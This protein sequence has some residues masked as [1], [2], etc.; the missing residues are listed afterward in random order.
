MSIYSI[1]TR[2]TQKTAWELDDVA[3]HA[4]SHPAKSDTVSQGT[5]PGRYTLT[6]SLK[7]LVSQDTNPQS[8]SNILHKAPSF[9]T[10]FVVSKEAQLHTWFL[11]TIVI[12]AWFVTLVQVLLEHASVLILCCSCLWLASTCCSQSCYIMWYMTITH[13]WPF[14]HALQMYHD[15]WDHYNRVKPVQA[16]LGWPQWQAH[17]GQDSCY[18]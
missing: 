16:R 15:T 2:Q 13:Q 1:V 7:T 3:T 10:V 17:R 14:R 11:S 9:S 12:I 18:M 4:V 8:W 6:P 5:N